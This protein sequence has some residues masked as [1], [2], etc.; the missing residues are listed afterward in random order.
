LIENKYNVNILDNNNQN[1]L[2]YIIISTGYSINWNSPIIEDDTIAKLN[3]LPGDMPYYVSLSNVRS[4][5]AF[6][7]N[8]FVEK[9][10]NIN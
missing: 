1:A 10:I 6:I 2:F 7:G 9:G 4:Q 5:A 3:F 8:F